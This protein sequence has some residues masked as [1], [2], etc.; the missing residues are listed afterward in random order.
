[1]ALTY[2]RDT[3]ATG[4]KEL[5]RIPVAVVRSLPP[6]ELT[7]SY[8]THASVSIKGY[9]GGKSKIRTSYISDGNYV[10]CKYFCTANLN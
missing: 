5:L 7:L 6:V 2:N 10:I 4:P 9:V 8:S 3:W 1:M